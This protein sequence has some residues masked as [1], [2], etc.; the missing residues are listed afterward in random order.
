MKRKHHGVWVAGVA[1]AALAAIVVYTLTGEWRKRDGGRRFPRQ[2]APF[3][4][5]P[6]QGQVRAMDR[7]Y[8][9]LHLLAAPGKRRV[10]AK[11]LSLFGYRRAMLAAELGGERDDRRLKE[12]EFQLSLVV[13]AGFGRYC[14]VDGD[15]LAEGDRLENGAQILKIENHRVLIMR[16]RQQKWIYLEKAS[17]S[18]ATATPRQQAVQ[19]RGP[20]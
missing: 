14:I 3:I 13:L 8:D 18:S 7:L 16:N 6:T 12:S 1:L 2:P 19:P 20:S 10:A 15:F 5:V 9:R 4:R 11:K 17:T